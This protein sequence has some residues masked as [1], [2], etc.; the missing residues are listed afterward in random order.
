[1]RSFLF[2]QTG[3]SNTD[4]YDATLL[5]QSLLVFDVIPAAWTEYS[6]GGVAIG[7]FRIAYRA[8][9]DAFYVGIGP[10]QIP[11]AQLTDPQVFADYSSTERTG[12]HM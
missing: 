11:A 5:Q 8:I 10:D 4:S 12:F 7:L 9:E 3:R 2:T 1:V 6:V